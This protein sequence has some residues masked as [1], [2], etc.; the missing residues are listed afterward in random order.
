MKFEINA[1]ELKNTVD[2]IFAAVPNKAAIRALED[3]GIIAD[4]RT[5]IT[6]TSYTVGDA[7]RIHVNGFVHE[8][9]EVHLN[10]NDLKKVY[11]IKGDI[12]T[13]ES[14]GD[15]LTVKSG[16]KKSTVL[17]DK[18][19]DY[20]AETKGM[21]FKDDPEEKAAEFPASKLNEVLCKLAVTAN[22]N[23]NNKL[24]AAIHVHVAAK[25]MV[26]LDGYRI[27]MFESDNYFTDNDIKA[28]IPVDVVPALKKILPKNDTAVTI[29]FT[30]K[31]AKFEG[32]DF[33]YVTRLH[34]GKYFDYPRMMGG[35][36][37]ALKINRTE[38]A[39]ATKEYKKFIPKGSKY[40]MYVRFDKA[41]DVFFTGLTLAD[42]RTS[43][44]IEVADTYDIVQKFIK[45]FNPEYLNDAA[46]ILSG[47]M[48]NFYIADYSPKTP[49]MLTD[50]EF[51]VLVLPVNINTD[52]MI[53][54]E[55]FT[56]A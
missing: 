4:G 54:F 6:F 52:E 51:K 10:K 13:V 27:G 5:N 11:A 15:T 9:G 39:E 35:Y 46:N 56:A 17:A 55:E 42:Y 25:Q 36:D 8:S 19:W 40:P 30:K 48:V 34:D 16:K 12:L 47:E 23:V 20:E 31:F 44:M 1:K 26:S 37:V 28:N 18:G 45:G 24:M 33:A 21:F 22:N 7:C 53:V 29:H 32:E 3:V 38:L 2:R 43:D 14:D 50:E 49:V 41:N